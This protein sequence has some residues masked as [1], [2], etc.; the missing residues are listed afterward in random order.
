[1]YVVSSI[2]VLVFLYAWK[3]QDKNLQVRS[4]SG[5][6]VETMDCI[7]SLNSSYCSSSRLGEQ[8][9]LI[10]AGFQKSIYGSDK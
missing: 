3:A 7:Y 1:M 6:L 4:A 8:L 9:R 10:L 5:T 2:S